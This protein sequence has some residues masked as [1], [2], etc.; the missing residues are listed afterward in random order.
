MA[1][2][3]PDHRVIRDPVHGYV[4]LPDSIAPLVDHPLF[5][6]LRWILQT[7]LTS[8]VYPS[9]TGS[10]FEHSL[11][12][13]HLARRGWLAAWESTDDDT[14]EAFLDA[15]A[16]DGISLPSS[17]REVRETLA[18][19]LAGAALLHDIGHPP[20]SHVLENVFREL[21]VTWFE[22][23]AV[24]DDDRTRPPSLVD[25][26]RGGTQRPFHEVAGLFLADQ[27]VGESHL[28]TPLPELIRAII[29]APE[30]KG[31]WASAAHGLIDSDVDI[32]RLDYLMRDA[33]KAGTEFGTMDHERLI[34]S[35][36]LHM[37]AKG[38][39][40]VA[41]GIRARSA[42][43]TLLVQRSQSYR[44]ITFHPRVVGTNLALRRAVEEITRN[45]IA[46]ALGEPLGPGTIPGLAKVWPEFNYLRPTEASVREVAR[47]SIP[48]GKATEIANHIPARLAAGVDDGRLLERLKTEWISL[49]AKDRLNADEERCRVFIETVLFRSKNYLIAWKTDEEFAAVAEGLV[50][51]EGLQDQIG[52][53]LADV[54][55]AWK[56]NA[57]AIR[58]I[59]DKRM[60]IADRFERDSPVAVVNYLMQLTLTDREA[61]AD[62]AKR[63]RHEEDL[64]EGFWEL[65]QIR[66]RSVK[67]RGKL[68][69]VF[70][71]NKPV[72][73]DQSS[74]MVQS[75][76]AMDDV[77]TSLYAFYFVTARGGVT[78]WRRDQLGI[79]RDQ[80]RGIFR[81][82]FPEFCHDQIKRFLEGLLE[83]REPAET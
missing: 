23:P 64:P 81:K 33:Q 58:L 49:R 79:S 44:W 25:A 36:E 30:A 12:A 22:T 77:Q 8:T 71:N 2:P 82:Q 9:A 37:V 1:A 15:I 21:A 19:A 83:R 54:A 14:H 60:D 48:E 38:R 66:F 74:P 47:T 43:E 73:L 3:H 41:P 69:R 28:A 34:S 65:E 39:F 56:G 6:R 26:L 45:P 24:T 32:D 68:L 63:L 80:L 35:M 31:T 67:E 16:A 52:D 59:E 20:F 42:I 61:R 76:I 57:E 55:E 29:H 11:G 51:E 4:E 78:A 50:R 10:R 40:L 18:D 17:P 75:L 7:S 72:R 53:A 62:L 46:E 70:A 5:Q 13:M 27:V